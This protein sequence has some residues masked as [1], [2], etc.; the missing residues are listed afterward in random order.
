MYF[1]HLIEYELEFFLLYSNRYSGLFVV[2]WKSFCSGLVLRWGVA[3]SVGS[4]FF[5]RPSRRHRLYAY[6]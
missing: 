2:A 3:G 5:W 6:P 1:L 4:Y